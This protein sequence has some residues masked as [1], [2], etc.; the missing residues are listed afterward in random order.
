MFALSSD[1]KEVMDM[2]Y[3]QLLEEAKKDPDNVDYTALRLMY[4]HSPDYDPFRFD[5]EAHCTLSQAMDA[6]NLPSALV[7]LKRLLNACYLDIH[8]HMLAIDVYENLR[9]EHKETFHMKFATGLLDSIMRSGDGTKFEKAFIVIS[10]Q[11]EYALLRVLSLE[12]IMQSLREN[13]GHQYDV[14]ECLH[15]HTGKIIEVYFNVD[16]PIGWLDRKL[17]RIK[18]SG[19][20]RMDLDERGISGGRELI[21]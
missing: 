12:T 15:P 19:T 1:N 7:A 14:F 16:L 18:L 11:E 5:S 2:T 3:Y 8:A 13:D 4:A 10:T 21:E 9:A 20:E 17:G 6:G